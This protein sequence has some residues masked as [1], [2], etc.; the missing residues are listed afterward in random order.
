MIHEGQVVVFTFPQTNLGPTKLRPALVLRKLPGKYNDWLTCM[1]SSKLQQRLD[2]LD[3]LVAESD[4]DYA[5]SGLKAP[6]IIRITRLAVQDL[7]LI[8]GAI[9]E[10]STGRLTRIQQNLSQWL[11][12]A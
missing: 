4:S 6:S 5:N 2:S 1:I 11:L 10:I 9:G 12:G 8:R 3:E 7:S